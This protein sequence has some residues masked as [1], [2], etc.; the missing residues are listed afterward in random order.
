M[1]RK[2]TLIGAFMVVS[3]LAARNALLL[4]GTTWEYV[5]F[6]IVYFLIVQRAKVLDKTEIKM[7]GEIRKTIRYNI[8][9]RIPQALKTLAS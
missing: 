1:Y 8:G 3:M 9:I 2:L 4:T 5:A 6:V 7:I